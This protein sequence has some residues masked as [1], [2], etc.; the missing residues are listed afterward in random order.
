MISNRIRGSYLQLVPI[1]ALSLLLLTDWRTDSN[2]A[3]LGQLAGCAEGGSYSTGSEG[4]DLED[5]DLA[6]IAVSDS[7]KLVLETGLDAI[8]ASNIIFPFRQS[9]S[10]SFISEGAS[11]IGALGWLNV[12][13]ADQCMKG[14]FGSSYTLPSA[15]NQTG[16]SFRDLYLAHQWCLSEPTIAQPLINW[17]FPYIDDEDSNGIIDKQYT[18]NNWQYNPGGTQPSAGRQITFS[19]NNNREATT[20]TSYAN[21]ANMDPNFDGN[22]DILDSRVILPEFQ[23]G[24]EVV[25]FYALKRKDKHLYFSKDYWDLIDSSTLTGGGTT[26]CPSDDAPSISCSLRKILE[27]DRSGSS[28]CNPNPSQSVYYNFDLAV[29][30]LERTTS[31]ACTLISWNYNNAD[32]WDSSS[33]LRDQYIPQFTYGLIDSGSRQNLLNFHGISFTGTTSQKKFTYNNRFNHYVSVAPPADQYR[34]LLG[35]EDLPGGGD[36]DFN[37]VVFMIEKKTGGTVNL[38]STKALTPD[39]ED[40]FIISATIKVAD[41]MPCSG[42]TVIDYFVSVDNGGNWVKINRDD[43]A[44]IE[45]PSSREVTDWDYG[46]PEKTVRE[47]TLNFIDLGIGGQELVW[48][49]DLLS[50]DQ[51][52]IPTID[53]LDIDFEAAKSHEFSRS[54]PTVLANV[55]YTTSYETPNVAWDEFTTRGHLY[56]T[57]LY[58]PEN[59]REEDSS[60][61]VQN[62]DAGLLLN[63]TALTQRKVLTPDINVKAFT[64]VLGRGRDA[65]DGL[66]NFTLSKKPIV[67]GSVTITDGREIFTDSR[68]SDLVGNLG[69]TGKIDRHTGAITELS[70]NSTVANNRKIRA[71]YSYYKTS[72]DMV[73]LSSSDI[74][75]KKLGIDDSSIITSRGRMFLDDYNNDNQITEDD[76]S[77]VKKWITGY[78]NGIDSRKEWIL[79]SIDHSTPAVVGAPAIHSWY[80][81]FDVS[82][83]VRSSYDTFMCEQRERATRVYAGSKIGM[84]HSFEAGKF[85]AYHIDE[86]MLPRSN[87][88][89]NNN[90]YKKAINTKVALDPIS[91]DLYPVYKPNNSDTVFINRGYYEWT[92]GNPDYG[93]GK[94]SWAVVPNDLLPRLKN[95]INGSEDFSEVDA[96]P[97]VVFAQFKDDSWH[98]VLMTAEGSGGDTIVAL[99]IT[100]PDDPKFLWEFGHPEL[101]RSRSSPSV[102]AIGQIYSSTGPVWVSFFVSGQNKVATDPASIFAIELETGR[103]IEKIVLYTSRDGLG[104][105][106]SGQPALID[107]DGNGYAD[108]MFI[109]T[110]KGYIYKILLPD[111]PDSSSNF[112]VCDSAFFQAGQPIHASPSVAIRSRSVGGSMAMTPVVLIGTS[113]SPYHIDEDVNTVTKYKFFSIGGSANKT[114]CRRGEKLWEKEL[115]AGHKVYGS[116]YISADRV[117]FGTS[118]GDTDDPCSTS[119]YV[120]TG[121]L[122]NLYVLDIISGPDEHEEVIENV[123]NIVSSPI[124]E[125]Q[126]LY[127]R[128]KEGE[129]KSY[130][131]GPYQNSSQVS[132]NSITVKTKWREIAN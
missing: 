35:L 40:A 89:S 36:F 72:P 48:K 13:M 102:S 19:R 60:T 51:E 17:I 66:F 76:A 113:D 6:S 86:S 16:I 3:S 18:V 9:A 10:I 21:N 96:S 34:W 103:L 39:D 52:C 122:G 58:S 118:V 87:K 101:F 31:S 7:G 59:A 128:T 84:I 62:W 63:S 131:D 68:T 54:S 108:K 94:E 41:T 55:V 38:K 90:T 82:S 79:P 81:G 28:P 5:Y 110:D 1:L 57:E 107:S 47:V 65:T 85:R 75:N 14:R 95:H 43:W 11:A 129:L 33:S 114:S 24:T 77:W 12:G 23:A 132:Q 121:T 56:S 88:C 116:A 70:F 126:H 78:K 105:T 2:A 97:S 49:A 30:A 26:V 67:F 73:N 46:S 32:Q 74:N 42:E 4:F 120:A 61:N 124:V 115:D 93:T 99:D 44:T 50:Q 37:D 53:E 15:T 111:E 83:D 100:S 119:G 127:I 123:G 71:T 98:A 112:Q 130:G 64:E 91:N 104:G 106:P 109:G 92:D 125:D 20:E 80:Y 22:L 45:T 69:G 117:Y 27:D 29:S 25:F 8:D